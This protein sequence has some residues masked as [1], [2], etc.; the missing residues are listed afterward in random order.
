MAS[1]DIA[2][3]GNGVSDGGPGTW[4][5]TTLNW[6][7]GTAP[8]VAWNN[9]SIST[10][11][12]GGTA[13]TV[14][15]SPVGI[16]AAGLEITG[17]YTFDGDPLTLTS[18]ASIANDTTVNFFAKIISSAGL[19]KSGIG[20]LV[21]RNTNGINGNLTISGGTLQLGNN[22]DTGSL[23]GP[24]YAG[25]IS[26][27]TG[28]TLIDKSNTTATLS[29]VISGGGILNKG[30]SGTLTLTGANTYT[31][32]TKILGSGAGGPAMSVSSFN[33]VKSG[34]IVT[35]GGPVATP[36]ASSSL[37]APKTV[38]GGTIEFG[39]A[40]NQRSST[41]YYT[42]LGETTDR[43][44]QVGFNS[45]SDQ[46]IY[47]NGSGLL[48][49]TSTFVIDRSSG[50]Q[51]ASLILRGTGN[52][53]MGGGTSGGVIPGFLQK[54]DAGS[55]TLGGTTT[56]DDLIVS[57][58]TLDIDGTLDAVTSAPT[59]GTGLV[60]VTGGTLRVDGLLS[61]VTTTTI[62]GGTV[63]GTGSLRFD[64]DGTTS[65]RVTMTSGALIATGL[66]IAVNATGSGLTLS[67]Y[68]LVNAT[69]GTLTGP[70]AG[71]TGAPGYELNYDTPNQVKLVKTGGATYASWAG[72]FGGL[73]D[74]SA[75]HDFDNGGLD[76][77]VEWVV[78]GDPA[79]GSD[80]AGNAPRVSEDGTYLVFTYNR[81]DDAKD[82]ANTA[83]TVEYG[84]DLDGW[85]PARNTVDGVIITPTPGSPFDVVEVKIPMSLAVGDKLFAR[86]NVVVTTP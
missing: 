35:G 42:G 12:F 10:A 54:T 74:P 66:T 6:D 61:F 26:I 65:D 76:T 53:E 4:N 71:V 28:A 9:T 25:N 5:T 73:S 72:G 38:S 59:P 7:E 45:G 24:S 18:A 3:D 84:S 32:R 77:G 39:S 63:S 49:F 85:T 48:K 43:V 64:I 15:I 21:L 75:S 62:S 58:G 70:F 52:G 47:A 68:L 30:G 29:G 19:T 67:E 36:I 33:S 14:T 34:S 79:D 78:G 13:G 83:I 20:T 17:A 11:I 51:G 57:G 22:A 2:T 46:T 55:W 81:R 69:G 56:V 44:M 50:G 8:H 23:S 31:G 27:A 86:I 41:L 80:D 16:S 37:G 82:D 1:T 60:T 40:G